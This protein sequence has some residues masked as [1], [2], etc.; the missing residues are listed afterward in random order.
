MARVPPADEWDVCQTLG[1]EE[2]QR[3]TEMQAGKERM[4]A[5]LEMAMRMTAKAATR[6]TEARTFR[7]AWIAA[8]TGQVRWGTGTRKCG[9][10]HVGRRAGGHGEE[11]GYG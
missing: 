7:G 10:R 11:D 2:M 3:D 8:R 1:R 6:N 9:R 4:V 5:G